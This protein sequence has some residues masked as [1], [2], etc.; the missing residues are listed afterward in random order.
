LEHELDAVM[1]AIAA[2]ET[3]VSGDEAPSMPS[4]AKKPSVQL[5][6]DTFFNLSLVDATKKYLRMAG[7]PARSTDEIAEA[8][9]RGGLPDVSKTSL[10][11][12]LFRAVKGRQIVKVGK[13]HWGLTE[14]YQGEP[15]VS[16]PTE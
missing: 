3:L 8:L 5:T 9:S 12:V 6:S 14:W 13:G 1:H 7:R 2:L 11:A 15:E 16:S 4:V 10:S